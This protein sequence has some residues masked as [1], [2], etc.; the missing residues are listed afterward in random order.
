VTTGERIRTAGRTRIAFRDGVPLAVREGDVVRELTPIE[1]SIA[2]AVT[3]RLSS[4]RRVP[5]ILRSSR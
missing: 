3:A 4:S 1:P 5:E 2:G